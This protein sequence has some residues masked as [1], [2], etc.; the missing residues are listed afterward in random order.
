M[1]KDDWERRKGMRRGRW[2]GRDWER[3]VGMMRGEEKEGEE[4]RI[5][6]GKRKGRE[7]NSIGKWRGTEEEKSIV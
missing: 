1:S 3:K 5:E 7:E 6:E 2:M 4:E